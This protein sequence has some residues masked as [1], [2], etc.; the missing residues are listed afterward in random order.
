MEKKGRREGLLERT[1]E[2]F[3]LPG[4]VVAGLPRVELLGDRQLRM[5]NHKG[6]LA[7]G[8]E[9]IHISGGKL[10]V[11]VRGANLTLRAMNAS[12]LLITGDIIG[13]DL[14]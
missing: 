10:I 4:D 13:V 11:K 1:A 2:V 12:E 9:E 5:E 14:A 7:Y 8:S 3:D 6:I